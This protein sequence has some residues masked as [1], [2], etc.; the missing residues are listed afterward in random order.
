MLSLI[1]KTPSFLE[2]GHIVSASTDTESG[3][4]GAWDGLVGRNQGGCLGGKFQ[5]DLNVPD[6]VP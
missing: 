1:L 3:T 2:N 5:G 4:G 6:C